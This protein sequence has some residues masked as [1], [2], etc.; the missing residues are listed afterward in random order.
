MCNIQSRKEQ[1]VGEG[2]ENMKGT[3]IGEGLNGQRGGGGGSS[4]RKK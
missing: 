3:D 1:N 4:S 2:K